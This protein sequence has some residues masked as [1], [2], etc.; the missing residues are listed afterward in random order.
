MKSARA[1]H[2]EELQ[3]LR[4]H[5]QTLLHERDLLPAELAARAVV[6]LS[7]LTRILNGEVKNPSIDT[8]ISLAKGLGT[9]VSEL[10]GEETSEGGGAITLAI[11]STD[12]LGLLRDVLTIA[13]SHAIH[14]ISAIAAPIGNNQVRVVLTL[15]S[16]N[17]NQLVQM[18]AAMQQLSGLT[19]VSIVGAKS[20]EI[21]ETN[22]LVSIEQFLRT[23]PRTHPKRK[24]RRTRGRLA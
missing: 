6:P 23:R 17:R 1:R 4:A 9:T 13:A 8:V 10:L 5:L 18:L 21:P 22:M 7:T 16:E 11:E 19:S 2:P 3:Y 24:P 20:S 12:R 15:E 14:I